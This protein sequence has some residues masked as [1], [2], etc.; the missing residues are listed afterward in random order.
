MNGK[1]SD[2]PAEKSSEV[3]LLRIRQ[4]RRKYGFCGQ[5]RQA[6]FIYRRLCCLLSHAMVSTFIYGGMEHRPECHSG[7][8]VRIETSKK[9]TRVHKIR[10]QIMGMITSST[11]PMV[12]K[13]VSQYEV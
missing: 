3:F 10:I 4:A 9:S 1:K 2:A 8:I 7:H 12:E 5:S 11:V 6:S 13:Y